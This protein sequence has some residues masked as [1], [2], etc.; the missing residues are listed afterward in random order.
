MTD[1]DLAVP[2]FDGKNFKVW[3]FRVQTI[4]EA[5]DLHKV[6][7]EIPEQISA[8]FKKKNRRAKAVIVSGLSGTQLSFAENEVHA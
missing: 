5:K 1:R 8:Y 2:V 3:K 7:E 6:L 4:L